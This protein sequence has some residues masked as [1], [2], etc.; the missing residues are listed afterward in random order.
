MISGFLERKSAISTITDL[1][2][3][4]DISQLSKEE[5][6]EEEKLEDFISENQ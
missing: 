4:I 1:V 6:Q 5:I 3:D 2:D